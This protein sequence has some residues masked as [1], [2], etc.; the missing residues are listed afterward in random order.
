V[1]EGRV[2]EQAEP[3][4]E[5]W[6]MPEDLPL[7]VRPVWDAA[8]EDLGGAGRMRDSYLPQLAIYCQS[9]WLNAAAGESLQ[10]DGILIEGP[11]GKVPN[12]MVKIHKDTAT[13]ILK[14][15]DALGLSPGARIRLALEQAVGMT[16][17]QSLADA[18]EKRDR[19]GR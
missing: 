11:F 19:R 7:E 9:V 13:T 10:M 1:I 4:A 8:V 18:R 12:P 17:L 6:P 3:P 14:Y 2:V 15:A 5:R 16:L